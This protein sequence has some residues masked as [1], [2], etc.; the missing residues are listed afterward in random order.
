M[1]NT[2]NFH[3][4]CISFHPREYQYIMLAFVYS[5]QIF[6]INAISMFRAEMILLRHQ[7][8]LR[9]L[10]RLFYHYY[11]QVVGYYYWQRHLVGDFLLQLEDLDW[12]HHHLV[13]LVE[14]QRLLVIMM[15]R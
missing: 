4:I 13:E 6:L 14:L 5:K 2:F 8:L 7:L 15:Q 9:H 3:F 1:F 10:V 11:Q 12:Q